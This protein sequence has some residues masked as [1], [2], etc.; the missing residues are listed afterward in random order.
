MSDLALDRRGVFL[1][2]DG[3]CVRAVVVTPW[4]LGVQDAARKLD[5]AREVAFSLW[6]DA[7]DVELDSGDI[8]LRMS[9]Q[10]SR[11]R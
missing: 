6:G 1:R 2:C 7:F 10:A 5:Y 8:L 4:R 9:Q 11:P 3:P